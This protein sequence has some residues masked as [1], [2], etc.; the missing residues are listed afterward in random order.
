M[1]NE[2]LRLELD[3]AC[4]ELRIALRNKQSEKD[5]RRDWAQMALTSTAKRK[6]AKSEKHS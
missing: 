1:N 3:F 6:E 5:Y 2:M 4:E